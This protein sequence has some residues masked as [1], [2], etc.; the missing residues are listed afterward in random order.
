MV[1]RISSIIPPQP[2]RNFLPPEF[3]SVELPTPKSEFSLLSPEASTNPLLK[4]CKI[5]KEYSL[6]VPQEVTQICEV[7][8]EIGGMALVVGGSVRDAV[9]V[10]HKDIEVYSKDFDLEI[11]GVDQEKVLEVL[12]AKFGEDSVSYEGASYRVIKVH[13]L[14][15]PEPLDVGLPRLD[16]KV[17]DTHRSVNTIA[18]E[19]PT[20]VQA[21]IRRDIK[22]NALFYNPLTGEIY[23]PFGGVENIKAD[24]VEMVDSETF[25]DDALRVLRLAQFVARF[26]WAVEEKTLEKCKEIVESGRADLAEVSAVKE[27]RLSSERVADEF[28]KLLTQGWT[29]S[30][31]FEFM[32]EVGLL[33]R[34]PWQALGALA[35]A[36]D[37]WQETMRNMNTAA[38]L[39][40]DAHS[41]GT[42][43][44]K[45][46]VESL[47]GISDPRKRTQEERLAVRDAKLAIS[48]PVLVAYFEDAGVD[49]LE[50][51]DEFNHNHFPRAVKAK[52][53]A[54]LH[55]RPADVEAM[56]AF[57]DY[58]LLLM[59]DR[60]D[61]VGGTF[62]E[63]TTITSVLAEG[64]ENLGQP[65]QVEDLKTKTEDLG[66]LFGNLLRQV[67]E[68]QLKGVLENR[69]D[70]L[71]FVGNL[72]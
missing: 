5:Y 38:E 11:F 23:D 27:G 69:E 32:K 13:I 66:P 46:V 22:A 3:P 43:L 20:L 53:I 42:L 8:R 61:K 17:G 71:R 16:E 47:N 48:L 70:G 39:L 59:A 40:W 57:S 1:Q 29:P 18:L 56:L 62:N 72:V 4:D 49:P 45:S 34:P 51:L 63:F 37:L 60:L 12:R 28:K 15:W 52:V 2:F 44:S 26:G 36:P 31:G 33:N 9:Y 19:S 58:G 68:R 25:G 14:G 55:E 21:A 64:K 67:R 50:F 7:F 10:E 24:I 54:Y 6:E 41:D 35:E 65:N 30:V